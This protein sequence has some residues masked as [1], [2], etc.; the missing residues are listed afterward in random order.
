MLPRYSLFFVLTVR[1][2]LRKGSSL[3]KSSDHNTELIKAH[4]HQANAKAMSLSDGSA[5]N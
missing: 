3:V 1:E 5:G 2:F 4:L